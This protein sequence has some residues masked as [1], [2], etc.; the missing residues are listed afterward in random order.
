M[1]AAA[2]AVERQH[3]HERQ[4]RRE[5][6]SHRSA[7]TPPGRW[8]A[9]RSRVSAS[10][11]D[12]DRCQG[13]TAATAP[14]R[15]APDR[16]APAAPNDRHA[17]TR[18]GDSA[19]DPG[20]RSG[21]PGAPS[22][23]PLDRPRMTHHYT[24]LHGGAILTFAWRACRATSASR[25]WRATRPAPDAAGPPRDGDL[26]TRTTASWPWAPTQQTRCAQPGPNSPRRVDL[27]RAGPSCRGSWSRTP[28][29]TGR[30]VVA[31]MALIAGRDR[32]AAIRAGAGGGRDA[33]GPDAW[34][35]ARYD[36]TGWD[37]PR[38]H[39]PATTWTAPCRDRPGPP[40]P[41]LRART[42]HGEQPGPRA[43][44]G[45]TRPPR[46][47]S[48]AAR[49]IERDRVRRADGDHPRPGRLGPASPPAVPAPTAADG[50]RGPGPRRAP[51]PPATVAP[52]ASPTPTSA[53]T[54]GSRRGARG[55]GRG[56]RPP[57]RCRSP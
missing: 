34:L 31:G 25:A 41:R 3:R 32:R 9:D 57:A 7:D 23:P 1:T 45:S 6:P 51:G 10:T 42:R 38:R 5:L 40:R 13:C 29:R 11:L 54:H 55:L 48:P 24:V 12:R 47:R 17:R 49:P 52:R 43:R 2:G 14:E 37:Q 46:G 33:S 22:L 18:L 30:D 15:S 36:P 35:V 19:S 28:T 21:A 8:R 4:Q 27:G 26:A 16:C 20:R 50:Q 39:R 56:D 44:R 53:A